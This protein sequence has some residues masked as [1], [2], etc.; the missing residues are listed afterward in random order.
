[1]E[2]DMFAKICMALGTV[3][4]LAVALPVQQAQASSLSAA[5][6]E[7]AY[8]AAYRRGNG[9][10]IGQG[11]VAG[12]VAGGVLGALL[13]H[14]HGRNI[15]GGAVA[16]TAAGALMGAAGSHRDGYINQR[17]YRIAYNNCMNRG[18]APVRLRDDDVR[19]CLAKYRSYNPRTGLYL[20]YGGRYL[21]CP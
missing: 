8:R 6:E 11:A 7:Q 4:I 12:A 2:D 5:C 17:A 3:S 9:D 16:G 13:G 14:G 1:M 18:L 20:S 21:P 10:A 19:Y 15:V